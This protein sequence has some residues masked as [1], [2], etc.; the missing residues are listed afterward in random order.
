MIVSLL[1]VC[2]GGAIGGATRYALSVTLPRLVST[3]IANCIACVVAGIA[4]QCF[5]TAT[6]GYA[7]LLVGVAG[8][9]STWSTLAAEL[10]QLLTENR[11]GTCFLYFG[12][13]MVGGT[14]ALAL[15]SLIGGLCA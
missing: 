9:L 6:L 11:Y 1:F 8:A 15:G 7:A 13:T 10:G 12:A 4:L 14:A 3:M 2:L 5:S